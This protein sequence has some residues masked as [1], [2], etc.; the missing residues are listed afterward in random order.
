MPF[1]TSTA[2]SG[3]VT[4]TSHND[5]AKKDDE[6][7]QFSFGDNRRGDKSPLVFNFP[8][9]S[10]EMMNE[11]DEKLGIKYTFGSKKPERI[12]FSSSAGSDGVCC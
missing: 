4:V 12:S 3:G 8:S 5:E 11:D 2:P 10:E 1:T 7:P 9:M 6:I